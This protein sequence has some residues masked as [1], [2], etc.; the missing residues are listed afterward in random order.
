MGRMKK[1]VVGAVTLVAGCTE[2][3]SSSPPIATTA[4]A[5]VIEDESQSSTTVVVTDSR[6]A[7]E[8]RAIYAG[9]TPTGFE[10]FSVTFPSAYKDTDGT[11]LAD[12][13]L[14]KADAVEVTH[15]YVDVCNPAT[16]NFER[17]WLLESYRAGEQGLDGHISIDVRSSTVRL[18]ASF[19]W[20]GMTD[21][22]GDPVQW[23]RHDID[24]GV[25]A[26]VGGE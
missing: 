2:G 21:R 18:R 12:I 6:H 16:E 19:G 23:H 26:T 20:E 10:W 25:L 5:L 11:I 8:L 17:C 1:Y 13:D 15:A 14:A 4:S 24:L 22:F 7:A 9:E 3:A